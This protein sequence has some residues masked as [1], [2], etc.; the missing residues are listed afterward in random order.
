MQDI[1]E[2]QS[3][4]TNSDKF[5]FAIHFESGS[6]LIANCIGLSLHC[7]TGAGMEV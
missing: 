2:L 6:M 4:R 5:D 7:M 1:A 3:K